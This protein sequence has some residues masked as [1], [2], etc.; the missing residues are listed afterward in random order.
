MSKPCFL[1]E[2]SFEHWSKWFTLDQLQD[3][4]QDMH[5]ARKAF[6]RTV[7]ALLPPP[8][9]LVHRCVLTHPPT[10]TLACV[11][12]RVRVR[13]CV[14]VR[15]RVVVCMCGLLAAD[16]ANVPPADPALLGKRM[17]IQNKSQNLGGRIIQSHGPGKRRV[18]QFGFF[19]AA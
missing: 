7:G 11:R 15:V 19:R 1:F 14:R 12:V 6:W 17:L 8:H 9:S 18:G 4:S 13:A 10:C 5:F 2:V 16:T 3:F